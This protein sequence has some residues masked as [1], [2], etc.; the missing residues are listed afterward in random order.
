MALWPLVDITTERKRTSRLRFQSF[1]FYPEFVVV[2]VQFSTFWNDAIFAQEIFFIDFFMWIQWQ[3]FVKY[4]W[5]FRYSKTF[6][7]QVYLNFSPIRFIDLIKFLQKVLF[8]LYSIEL[9]CFLKNFFENI[10]LYSNTFPL[11]RP[12][13]KK[14]KCLFFNQN[15]Y[16]CSC[17]CL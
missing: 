13:Y 14:F 17:L 16:L 6:L 15:I 1:I 4:P 9:H 3:K 12:Q 10:S 8:L 11:F 5:K 2:S 7:M